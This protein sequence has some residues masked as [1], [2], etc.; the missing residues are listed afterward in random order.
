MW[1]DTPG[2]D[3]L[4]ELDVQERHKKGKHREADTESVQFS[5][6]TAL[7]DTETESEVSLR[8]SQQEPYG[9]K[10]TYAG[11]GGSGGRYASRDAMQ[12]VQSRLLHVM[13]KEAKLGHDLRRGP[14]D[15]SSGVVPPSPRRCPGLL[16]AFS[17]HSSR[18]EPLHAFLWFH[19]ALAETELGFRTGP[20]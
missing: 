6:A 16:P 1:Y 3:N 20:A 8:S 15:G 7:S 10:G 13:R 4:S 2:Y 9:R 5:D 14:Y 17:R 19:F 18:P 12:S 11:E